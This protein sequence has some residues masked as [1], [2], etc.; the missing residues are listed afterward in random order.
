MERAPSWRRAPRLPLSLSHAQDDDLRRRHKHGD[1][2]LLQQDPIHETDGQHVAPP[3]RR[4][5]REGVWRGGGSRYSI[6]AAVGVVPATGRAESRQRELE[7]EVEGLTGGGRW[8]APPPTSA[9]RDGLLRFQATLY[10]DPKAAQALLKAI[11][12]ELNLTPKVP[13]ASEGQK[14]ESRTPLYE[15]SGSA[16][17]PN[18]LLVLNAGGPSVVAGPGFEPGT[19]GL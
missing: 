17:L 16:F 8:V 1:D 13:F 19:F 3:F 14:E 6:Y 4:A 11:I 18:L 10:L 7:A 12:G 5:R 15:V 2:D 9:I